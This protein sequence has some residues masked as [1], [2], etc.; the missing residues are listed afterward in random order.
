MRRRLLVLT[1]AVIGVLLAALLVPTVVS[2]A[3]AR[4][5]ESARAPARRRHPARGARGRRVHRAAGARPAAGPAPL[6]RGLRRRGGRARRRR[7]RAR[8]IRH[9]PRPGGRR[10]RGGGP[11]R[12]PVH[13]TRP[14]LALAQRPD[15]DRDPDRARRPGARCGGRRAAHR[16][17][18]TGGG[19]AA[20]ARRRARPGRA[21]GGRAA[22]RPPARRL[23]PAPGAG[24]GAQCAA[25]RR[26]RHHGPGAGSGTAR[27]CGSLATT[28]NT[29]AESVEV[30][31]RQQRDLVAD[32]SHQPGQ[33]GDRAPAA[34]GGARRGAGRRGPGRR[35]RGDRPD[36]ASAGGPDR[37]EQRGLP[38]PGAH[39]GGPRGAGARPDRPVGAAVRSPAQRPARAGH[40][41][42]RGRAGPR[43]GGGRRPAGQRAQVRTR[44]RGRVSACAPTPTTGCCS[45]ATTVP[46]LSTAEVDELGRRFHRLPRHADVEGTGLGLAIAAGRLRDA[47]GSLR[48]AAAGPGLRAEVRIP[49]GRAS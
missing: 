19:L 30:S 46:S 8:R 39:R 5:R 23:D 31:Q 40:G 22:R 37:G 35:D 41:E 42:R 45:F 27:A 28:F 49:R 18:T 34:P 6:P 25:S 14:G 20:R 36:R 7:H 9:G 1:V 32:V 47:G 11:R 15:G 17:R 13:R 44:C 48:L 38:R 2:D 4:T 33:P 26:G 3:S 24:P 29:M 43:A 21:G 10:R 12:Q 16:R